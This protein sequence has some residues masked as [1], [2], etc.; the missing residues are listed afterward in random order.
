MNGQE[1]GH[2]G[3]G[4]QTSDTHYM[5]GAVEN[6]GGKPIAPPS[7]N[8]Y[9]AEETTRPL[10]RHALG[11]TDMGSRYDIFRELPVTAPNPQAALECQAT[12]AQ[13]AYRVLGQNCL[14][15]TVQILTAYGVRGLP[16]TSA[17]ENYFPI[18]WFRHLGAANKVLTKTTAKL[19]VSFYEHPE[20]EGEV[21][22]ICTNQA[23]EKIPNLGAW[24]KRIS[25]MVVRSG[26]V[27][28]FQSAQ[29][30]HASITLNQSYAFLGGWT[31][32]TA[33]LLLEASAAVPRSYARTTQ[34]ATPKH[35]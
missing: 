2:V 30:Q 19:D 21:W 11:T 27:T 16:S 1:F 22:R 24:S 32:E 3:W 29:F 25:S 20:F 13:R 26:Q 5:V 10:E 35:L 23:Q 15:A 12:V 6:Y 18:N 14:D 7:E 31:R 8:G 28:L 9:W 33:S 34:L 4:F 17:M